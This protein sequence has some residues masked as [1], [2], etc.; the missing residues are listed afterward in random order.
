MSIKIGKYLRSLIVISLLVTFTTVLIHDPLLISYGH[1]LSP[2]NSKAIGDIAI[3][4]GGGNRTET[5]VKLF[6]NGQVKALYADG[7][8]KQNLMEIASANGLPFNKVYWGGYTMNTFDEA[9]TFRRTINSVNFPYQK[10]VIVSDK[11]H[12]QRSKWAFRQV[13]GKDVE[14]TTYSTPSNEAMSDPRWWKHKQSRDWVIS[15][16][17]KFVYYK[18]YYGFLGSR[19]PFSPDEILN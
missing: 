12:L 11:Y 1:W 18:I 8:D 16:T 10:V 19:T 4:L 6:V 14:I 15:E 3:C 17:Q 2:S 5:G 13:L 7:I 9:L